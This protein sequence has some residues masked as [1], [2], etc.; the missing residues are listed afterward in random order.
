MKSLG[1]GLMVAFP[2]ALAGIECAAAM[3][4]RVA[5]ISDEDG[6]P[7]ELLIGINVGEVINTEDDFFGTPVVVAKRLCDRAEPGQT[8]VTELVRAGGG[9]RGGLRFVELGALALK[10]FADRHFEASFSWDMATGARIPYLRSRVDYIDMLLRRDQPR[11]REI[12]A[13]LIEATIAGCRELGL[14]GLIGKL[15]AQQRRLT[16]TD[17]TEATALPGR[18]RAITGGAKAAL[19]VRGRNAIGRMVSGSTD[20]ELE[21]RFESVVAQRALLTGMAQGFQPRMALGFEGGIEI[22]LARSRNDPDEVR[23]WVLVVSGRRAALRSG[24]T[25]SP[26]VTIETDVATFLRLFRG[27]LN[28]LTAW[29]GSAVSISGDITLGPRLL[30]L[31]GGVKPVELSSA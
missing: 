25:D 10:G 17:A 13:Q 5:T 21:R 16:G 7:L 15:S 11:D 23:W 22:G 4:Q 31:F 14:G 12:A 27:D 24:R 8:L 29:L 20:E 2:S 9:T 3:H 6:K 18:I 30:E 19:S 26:A 1:D 28:P